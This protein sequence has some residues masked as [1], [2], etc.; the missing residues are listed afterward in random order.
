M[1][2]SYHAMSELRL[3][4]SWKN[5]SGVLFDSKNQQKVV[6]IKK[7]YKSD[8]VNFLIVSNKHFENMKSLDFSIKEHAGVMIEMTKMAN[9]LSKQRKQ[10]TGDYSIIINNGKQSRQTVFHFHAHVSSEDKS[11]WESESKNTKP[12]KQHTKNI[13]NIKNTKNTKST[14]SIKPDDSSES[15]NISDDVSITEK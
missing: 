15:L 1:G 9:H 2:Q 12:P 6:R 8:N 5:M 11:W 7:L 10:G 4:M 13:K 14:K 3:H